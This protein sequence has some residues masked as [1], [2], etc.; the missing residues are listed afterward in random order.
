MNFV[1]LYYDESDIKDYK[2]HKYNLATRQDALRRFTDVSQFYIKRKSVFIAGTALLGAVV[3]V[4]DW[5]SRIAMLK[6]PFIPPLTFLKFD[7]LGIPMLLSYFLFG[8][9]S[10]TVTSLVAWFSISFRDPFS[11]F[12]KFLAEFSTMIGVYLVLRTRS[13]KSNSWKALSMLSGITVR[14]TVM[15]AANILLLPIFMSKFYS[16]YSAV[17]VL[18]PLISLFNAIQGA[19][20]VFGGLLLYEAVILRLPSLKTE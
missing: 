11:G 2:K 20:S 6:I 7:A 19:V 5:A 15:A 13:P 17:I 9:F 3:A 14:V 4:L 1:Q 18:I 16:T 10:G 8:F 12:M